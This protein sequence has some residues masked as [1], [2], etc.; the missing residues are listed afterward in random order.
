MFKKL[1]KIIVGAAVLAAMVCSVSVGFAAEIKLEYAGNTDFSGVQGHNNWYYQCT[2]NGEN[3]TDLPYDE[4]QKMWVNGSNK[5]QSELCHPNIGIYSARVWEAPYS[6]RVKLT[7]KGNVR[8]NKSNTVGEGV[9]VDIYINKE[10][11]WN[12]FI[13]VSDDVGYS[14]D[15]LDAINVKAGDRI[16]FRVGCD[17]WSNCTTAWIPIVKYENA[18]I[19]TDSAGNGVKTFKALKDSALLNCT[20][21]DAEKIDEDAVVYLAVYDSENR[22]KKISEADIDI[23]NWENRTCEISVD[24]SDAADKSEGGSAELM[25]LTKK[26]GRYYSALSSGA[27]TLD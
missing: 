8:M 27:I 1:K 16:Y 4:S 10:C 23:E 13:K 24:I 11:L 2:S 21:Y 20:F 25:V 14:Y 26:D 7:S 3:Y 6:G 15:D 5:I 19:F 22:L 9:Y 12:K 17:D 18:A